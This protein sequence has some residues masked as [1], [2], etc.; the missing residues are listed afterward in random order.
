MADEF[1]P[2]D[3]RI[4]NEELL[5]LRVFPDPD[6]IRPIG[7]EGEYRPRSGEFRS[8]GPLSVDRGSMCTREQTRDRDTSRPY[9]VADIPA[10]VFRSQGCR[11]VWEPVEANPAH[12]SIYGD[13]FRQDGTK[14]GVP[15][16][17]LTGSQTKGV[18][19]QVKIS[20]LNPAARLPAQ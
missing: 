2:D 5:Y 17:S 14:D 7:N 8:D 9:H 20:L 10:W 12:T 3:K 19:R 16:G 13:H 18:A 15:D 6:C 1:P 11:V 4:P